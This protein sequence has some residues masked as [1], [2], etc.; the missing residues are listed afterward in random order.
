MTQPLH[1]LLA[2]GLL[3]AGLG[4]AAVATAQTIDLSPEQTGRIHTTKNDAAIAAIPADA[5]LVREGVLTVA[6]SVASSP[7]VTYATDTQTLVGNDVDIAHL[8]AE[9]LGK[10]LELV[11]V[12]WADWPLGLQ[13]G[14]YDAVISNVTVTEERKEKFDF[15]TYREDVIGF[16]VPINSPITKISDR[17]D[18]AGLRVI[19]ESGTNQEKILLEWNRLNVKAGLAP[20]EV[21]YHDDTSVSALALQS[22]RADVEF[23]NNSALAYRAT[24]G[25]TRLVG[26]VSGGWPISA[27]IGVATK[28][29]SRL[30]DAITLAI[31]GLIA[32]GSYARTLER[33]RLTPEGLEKSLTNPPG[34]PKT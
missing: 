30:A 2:A 19:T 4:G 10:K 1:R 8:I 7:F 24:Q 31:N 21:Q 12:A 23:N 18:I 27:Q 32:D 34:L 29:N 22:G 16:Y 9:G 3:A 25:G 6:V 26:L 28:K 17:A 13:S 14:K 11:P 15:S 5:K 20:I 33:W